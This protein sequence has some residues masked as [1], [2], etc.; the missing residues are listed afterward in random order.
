MRLYGWTELQGKSLTLTNRKGYRRGTLGLIPTEGERVD[1][2]VGP[3]LQRVGTDADGPSEDRDGGEFPFSESLASRRPGDLK[4]QREVGVEEGENTTLRDD[5]PGDATA[6]G[7][8]GGTSG[9][10]R[11]GLRRGLADGR[12]RVGRHREDG[13]VTDEDIARAQAERRALVHTLVE[14]PYVAVTEVQLTKMPDAPDIFPMCEVVP[15][16]I[17]V[18]RFP[19]P[20][21]LNRARLEIELARVR[22]WTGG[23]LIMDVDMQ[24]E[25]G[26]A[27]GDVQRFPPT[28]NWVFVAGK[29]LT[30]PFDGYGSAC[31]VRHTPTGLWVIRSSAKDFR[32]NRRCCEQVL[33]VALRLIG[34][35]VV[36]LRA[37]DWADRTMNVPGSSPL[38][39]ELLPPLALEKIVIARARRARR[40]TRQYDGITV[41]IGRGDHYRSRYERE[42]AFIID[43]RAKRDQIHEEFCQRLEAA[44]F[45]RL[46][47]RRDKIWRIQI[48]WCEECVRPRRGCIHRDDP[49]PEPPEIPRP[50]PH[51]L[52]DRLNA[53]PPGS[54]V[55]QHHENYPPGSLETLMN[56]PNPLVDDL[57]PTTVDD[58]PVP[59]DHPAHGPDDSTDP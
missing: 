44:E 49:L 1:G 21:Q 46:R 31:R 51:P 17:V 42:M 11:A 20:Q 58:A 16:D 33:D 14:V 47:R 29:G 38:F 12:T 35:D 48:L 6:Q 32:Y 52:V 40:P 4:E 28:A 13:G 24:S 53:R 23:G 41:C 19:T 5:R 43:A 37:I 8:R 57:V 30:I 36:E 10:T 56:L 2:R 34:G 27:R 26:R 50:V 59:P 3:E 7:K 9:H 45:L 55:L 25:L 54:W 22:G 18:E 39:P 15:Q